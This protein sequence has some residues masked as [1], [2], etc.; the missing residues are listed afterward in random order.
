MCPSDALR[1]ILTA[2]RAQVAC[3][4]YARVRTNV[5]NVKALKTTGKLRIIDEEVETEL[6]LRELG[7]SRAAVFL[8]SSSTAVRGGH[9]TRE[10]D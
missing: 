5:R 7:S 4:I 10:W 3:R 1:S 9:S 6:L 8:C 2:S